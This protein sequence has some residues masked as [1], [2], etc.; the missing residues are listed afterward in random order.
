MHICFIIFWLGNFAI[1]TT[2]VYALLTRGG[3]HIFLLGVDPPH[4]WGE[5]QHSCTNSINFLTLLVKVS[6]VTCRYMS[7]DRN[8]MDYHH[9]LVSL[10]PFSLDKLCSYFISSYVCDEMFGRNTFTPCQKNFQIR[11]RYLVENYFFYK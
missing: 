3:S 6:F 7:R 11:C 5:C 4:L 1:R 9:N 10:A 2:P 8:R